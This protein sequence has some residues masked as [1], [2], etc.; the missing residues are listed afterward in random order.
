VTLVELF[1]STAPLSEAD[2]LLLQAAWQEERV[3]KRGEN[4]LRPGQLE[5]YVYFVLEGSLRIYFPNDEGE[6]I[7][8]GFGYPGNILSA[9]PSFLNEEPSEFGISALRK[10][11]LLKISKKKLYTLRESYPTIDKIWQ[12]SMEQA[13]IGL[14]ERESAML[15]KDPRK[16]LNKL[17]KRSP[18]IFQH[19]P[20]KYIASYL[21]MSPET[22]SRI[23]KAL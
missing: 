2:T 17:L 14:I 6:E 22:L 1:S 15:I 21:R 12:H 10:S 23:F 20:Q 8:I 4:L 7:C 3:L 5:R 19:V 18:H 16:R 9:I 13:L 11:K